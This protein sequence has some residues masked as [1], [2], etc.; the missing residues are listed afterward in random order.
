[1]DLPDLDRYQ[2]LTV[3]EMRALH[4]AYMGVAEETAEEME[5]AFDMENHSMVEESRDENAKA[6]DRAEVLFKLLHTTL[7]EPEDE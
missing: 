5:D 1:M 6:M 2:N 4:S 7:T 3:F